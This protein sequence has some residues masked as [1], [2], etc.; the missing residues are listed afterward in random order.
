M[1]TH[2]AV[3]RRLVQ[4]SAPNIFN[5]WA[6]RDPLD[7]LERSAAL[8]LA[9]LRQHFDV[10]AQLLLIGEAAGYQGCHFSGIAFTSERLLLEGIA[11]RI[12]CSERLTHRIR[13]WSEPSATTVWGC[14]HDFGIAQSTVLWNA[15]PWHPHQ[16]NDLYTNRRPSPAEL[17][18]G[19]PVLKAVLRRFKGARVVAVG[20]IAAQLL[21]ELLGTEP[22]CI[23]HP[24]MAGASRFR[25]ELRSL[26]RL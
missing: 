4:F 22:V 3:Y 11:P 16:P 13:P 15:F 9:R 8:R 2:T 5:P 23:R 12:D 24:S 10:Q 17:R 18:L 19:A 26:L 1:I 14:L 21:G 20:R 7:R 6:D 25:S